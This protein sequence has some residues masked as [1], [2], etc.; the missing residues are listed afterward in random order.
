MRAMNASSSFRR[1]PALVATIGLLAGA[2][3]L[4]P[5]SALAV[6]DDGSEECLSLSG[7]I[8]CITAADDEDDGTAVSDGS[9]TSSWGDDSV[10]DGSS[11]DDG[12]DD[13]SWGEDTSVEVQLASYD[14][15]PRPTYSTGTPPPTD[16]WGRPYMPET[17]D[18]PFAPESED[19]G[20]SWDVPDGADDLI[21]PECGVL[22]L[23]MCNEF[24]GD[25]VKG[26]SVRP[27]R[28]GDQSTDHWDFD[29]KK[30]RKGGRA[31]MRRIAKH[32]DRQR[33]ARGGRRVD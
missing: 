21:F 3:A 31:H 11:W 22:H 20:N 26:R 25:R 30:S 1:I 23:W 4:V 5:G 9:D 32:S 15:A 33:P 12:S 8:D 18:D 10:D 16:P 28:K 7:S 19:D 17:F 6:M 27:A 29:K 14:N 24:K 2:Q 13:S